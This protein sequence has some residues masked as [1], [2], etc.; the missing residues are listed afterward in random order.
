[1]NFEKR[2]QSNP[3]LFSSDLAKHFPLKILVA[4]DNSVNQQLIEL[5]LEQYGYCCDIVSD[6]VEVIEAIHRCN[7]D[8]ILMD[9][10]M[11]EMDGIE[12]TR[13]I[14]D[15]EKDSLQHIRIIA[16][17]ASAMQG[18]R[19]NFLEAG[20]D[21]YI[22]KPI[23]FNE[24]VQAILKYQ[25]IDS[26][27]KLE[28]KG[29]IENDRRA[30]DMQVF[31]GLQSM[32]GKQNTPTVIIR[33]IDTYL[34]GL[35]ECQATLINGIRNQDVYSLKMAS[36]SLK[37]TSAALGAINLS[38]FCESIEAKIINNEITCSGEELLALENEF[39]QECDRVKSAFE[40]QKQIILSR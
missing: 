11:P 4:E 8:L 14:R 40:R 29:E 31:Q 26:A 2:L 19:Q 32:F 38:T 6:G 39:V 24:L 20:M 36:H 22:S 17:T 12:A 16:V 13:L 18:D 3:D 5:M 1:M 30:I 15:L 35:D 21:D 25:S 37:S 23:Q 9:V 27:Q 33:L 34:Q 28:R 7:Y 10:Q